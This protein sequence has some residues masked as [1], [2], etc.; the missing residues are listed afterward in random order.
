[1]APLTW[2]DNAFSSRRSD[3]AL[4]GGF[5]I[6]G[7]VEWWAHPKGIRSREGLRCALGPFPTRELAKAS[8]D[9]DNVQAWT[10]QAIPFPNPQGHE[11][12]F[13]ESNP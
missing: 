13:M 2:T 6:N 8:L 12:P 11:A 4:V 10:T 1:M 7:A 3:G 5:I 9:P